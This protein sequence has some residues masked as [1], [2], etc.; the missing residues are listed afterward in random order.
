[1]PVVRVRIATFHHP[2]LLPEVV[3]GA[4]VTAL[5]WGW[6]VPC[7]Y[8]CCGLGHCYGRF[9]HHVWDLL[10]PLQWR[11]RGWVRWG[12]GAWCCYHIQGYQFHGHC[13][14]GQRGQ[15]PMGLC[16]WRGDVAIVASV[17]AVAEKPESVSPALP[18]PGFLW[19]PLLWLRSRISGATSTGSPLL[20]PLCISVHP[21]F[22]FFFWPCCL[23][24]LSS[25][26]RIKTIQALGSES[27]ASWL[28][29]CQ[30]IFSL[31]SLMY[32][33]TDVWKSQQSWCIG[34]RHFYW[35]K[36]I[37]LLIIVG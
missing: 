9:L 23:W 24:D 35:V 2:L 25:P 22:F 20:P 15:N 14:C 13:C 12:A 30:R 36:D 7:C 27:L 16:D 33:C 4:L 21:L 1:M 28:L 29:D 11:G 31:S 3:S 19:G 32:S 6:L 26:A 34:Q 37:L 18:L 17:T 8:Q 10:A 5:L